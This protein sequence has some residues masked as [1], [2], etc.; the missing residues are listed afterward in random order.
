MRKAYIAGTGLYHPEKLVPNSYFNELYKS[1]I[2]TFLR[3][4]RNIFQRYFMSPEQAT[5]DL[6]VPAVEKALESAK[7]TKDDV[8]LLIVATDTPD[9]LSPSTAAVVQ[10]F[11]SQLGLRGFCLGAGRRDQ[12]SPGGRRLS[13]HRRRR[14][15]RH[16]Q[17]P[18][19]G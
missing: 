15:V 17:V 6:I 1:D 5:S 10:H 9:Y 16:E 18:Q 13:Q 7:I 8:D 14:R 3:E 2:D 19:L 12:V 11:R 4:K